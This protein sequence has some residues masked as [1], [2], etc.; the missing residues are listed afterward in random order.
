MSFLM[1]DKCLGL[2]IGFSFLEHTHAAQKCEA[3][4]EQKSQAV[5][6]NIQVP[7]FPPLLTSYETVFRKYIPEVLRGRSVVMTPAQSESRAIYGEH[8]L[9]DRG[10]RRYRG[11]R[12]QQ[13]ARRKSEWRAR[14]RD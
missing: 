4:E 5:F 11:L 3:C 12:G 13:K 1:G 14:I 6:E 8:V 9:N 10:P 2:E 7:N